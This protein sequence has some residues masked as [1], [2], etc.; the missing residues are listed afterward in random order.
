MSAY[1]RAI[2][3]DGSNLGTSPQHRSPTAAASPAPAAPGSGCCSLRPFLIPVTL[4]SHQSAGTCATRW[5]LTRPILVFWSVPTVASAQT[6]LPSSYRS[7]CCC[8]RS[9]ALYDAPALTWCLVAAKSCIVPPSPSQQK[10]PG[11]GSVEVILYHKHFGLRPIVRA[12]GHPRAQALAH[13][14]MVSRTV[15]PPA[16]GNAPKGLA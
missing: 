14:L 2:P 8:S 1:H 16:G 7:P 13:S 4:H 11:R 12:Q 10:S 5:Q 6:S 9:L 3:I 15:P